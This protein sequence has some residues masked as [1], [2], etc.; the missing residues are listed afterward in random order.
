[1]KKKT[2]IIIAGPTASGKTSLALRLA[3]FYRTQ[4]ISADSRQCFTELNIGVA[5]PTAAELDQVR[6]YFINAYS[7]Q[8][9]VNAASFERYALTAAEEI[10]E[11]RDVAIMVGGTGLYIKAFCEG[12][13]DI[14][15]IEQDIRN[16][17]ITN[18]EHNG[19]VWLQNE[20]KQNDP[21]YWEKGEHQ[22]PQRLIRALEV[23]T[24]TGNSI[25]SYQVSKNVERPFNI[26]KFALDVPREDL[27]RNINHRVDI[28]MRD[29]L[30]FEVRELLPLRK[31]N[32]LQTVGYKELFEHIDG[33]CTL[34]E[35]VEEIKRNTR[36]YA[37][38][39]FTWFKK[40]PEFTWIG[41][42]TTAEEID[43]FLKQKIE[44]SNNTN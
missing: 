18:Y 8:D 9:S 15:P 32:A 40:D 10:F 1:L 42:E 24:A 26:I 33:N 21:E 39:Q 22:N 2:V 41:P 36:H 4:I 3:E 43:F 27:Y 23:I 38:R 6:H 30:L 12:L 35:A 34:E 7:V 14:P 5:K 13:D 25:L 20:V 37:K 28:M 29:G 31:L 11:E 19:L 44:G 17:I 16:T